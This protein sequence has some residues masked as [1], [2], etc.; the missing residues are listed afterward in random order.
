MNEH[1]TEQAR[2]TVEEFALDA[3]AETLAEEP[4]YY[5]KNI[6]LNSS[7]VIPVAQWKHEKFNFIQATLAFETSDDE[8]TSLWE[9]Y[10]KVYDKAIVVE[11]RR[12]QK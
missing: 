1:E 11:L 4:H 2:D 12:M 10:R 6:D 8:H 5:W 3:V 9:L 7:L